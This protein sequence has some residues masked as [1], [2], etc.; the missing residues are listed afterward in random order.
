MTSE[1]SPDSDDSA[2]SLYAG[3]QKREIRLS[4]ENTSDQIVMSEE[5]KTSSDYSG[6]EE[7]SSELLNG[8]LY[9]SNR[10]TTQKPRRSH[11][12]SKKHHR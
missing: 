5:K 9:T 1:Q 8:S 7:Y 12:K 11:R 4:N 2:L 6:S 10:I 3:K